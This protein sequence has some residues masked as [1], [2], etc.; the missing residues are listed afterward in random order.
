[1]NPAKM[2]KNMFQW[3]GQTYDSSSSGGGCCQKHAASEGSRS[4]AGQW[5]RNDGSLGTKRSTRTNQSGNPR[6]TAR[7]LTVDVFVRVTNSPENMGD[8]KSKMLNVRERALQ[9]EV[10]QT[11]NATPGFLI[12]SVTLDKA[13]VR[14]SPNLINLHAETI[15]NG[16]AVKI[17]AGHQARYR[18]EFAGIGFLS[19]SAMLLGF[20]KH[21]YTQYSGNSR[22]NDLVGRKLEFEVR[23]NGSTIFKQPDLPAVPVTFS[24]DGRYFL[25]STATGQ[26]DELNV[27]VRET[28]RKLPFN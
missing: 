20:G 26:G 3:T 16:K 27:I 23:A 1:M 19:R 11:I 6:P 15:D 21:M 4:T 12:K 28:P 9:S 25:I 22:L 14:L 24:L 13:T 18:S 7:T 17:K 2:W 10:V 5:G 8:N